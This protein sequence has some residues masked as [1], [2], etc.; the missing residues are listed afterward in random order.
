[1]T[2][3]SL[4]VV[5]CFISFNG[6]CLAEE[7]TDDTITVQGTGYPPIRAE[8]AAQARLMAKRAAIVHAYRNALSPAS[9]SP[10]PPSGDAADVTYQELS[11]FVRGVTIVNEEYL[12]D[13]GIRITAKV[14]KKNIIVSTVRTEINKSG[15]SAGPERVSLEEWYKIINNLVRIDK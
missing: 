15:G 12:K 14:P 4:V 8:S 5:F 2:I 13:G 3:R 1:M 11:G 10:A 7:T 9:P 6:L